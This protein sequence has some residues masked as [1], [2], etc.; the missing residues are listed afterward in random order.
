MECPN[1]NCSHEFD[2]DLSELK[3]KVMVT[4]A[5]IQLR[6]HTQGVLCVQSAGMRVKLTLTQM[7]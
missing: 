5:L 6:T 7:K 4:L 2:I 3:E 1:D